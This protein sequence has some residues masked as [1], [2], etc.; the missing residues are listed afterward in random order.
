MIQRELEVFGFLVIAFSI[1][2]AGSLFI[3]FGQF[4]VRK[5]RRN[6]ATRHGLGME[7]MHGG[8]IG[9]VAQ[10]LGWPQW[11]QE[12]SERGGLRF[13]VADSQ[14]IHRHTTRLDRALGRACFWSVMLAGILAAIFCF[15]IVPA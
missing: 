8:D 10:A 7:F 11:V 14:S 4:T 2:V 1:L 15:I 5:L 13:L 3:A 9:N 6:P 12:R